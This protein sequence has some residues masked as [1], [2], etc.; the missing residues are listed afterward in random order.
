MQRF[1]TF[2]SYPTIASI[3]L[4]RAAVTRLV[5]FGRRLVSQKMML[6]GLEMPFSRLCPIAKR[7]NLK[8]MRTGAVGASMLQSR[9][10]TAA[11]W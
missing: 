7:S 9:D 4:I 3:R 2:V 6:R 10:R 1:L 5:S 11:L 8:P